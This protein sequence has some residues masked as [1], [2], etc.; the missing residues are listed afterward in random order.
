MLISLFLGG[1]K[2]REG[3]GWGPAHWPWSHLATGAILQRIS[4]WEAPSVLDSI[5]LLVGCLSS[6]PKGGEQNHLIEGVAQGCLSRQLLTAETGTL[7]QLRDPVAFREPVILLPK[8]SY[9][10]GTTPYSDR[11]GSGITPPEA[12]GRRSDPDPRCLRAGSGGSLCLE[13]GLLYSR[14]SGSASNRAPG[15]SLLSAS[16]FADQ[17][18]FMQGCV[19]AKLFNLHCVENR[20]W[21]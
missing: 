1:T 10:K 21:S 20:M 17:L 2:K 14:N 9:E 12:S 11:L 3:W 15:R 19:E 16:R 7:G 8:R 13:L 18:S 5:M 4:S 6:L